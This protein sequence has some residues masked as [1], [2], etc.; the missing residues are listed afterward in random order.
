MLR[1]PSTAPEKFLIKDLNPVFPD[2]QAVLFSRPGQRKMT[3]AS[4]SAS[5][6]S[7]VAAGIGLK[8][9]DIAVAV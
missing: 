4:K 8:A 7:E 5:R 1:F 3:P 6:K 9:L 2:C